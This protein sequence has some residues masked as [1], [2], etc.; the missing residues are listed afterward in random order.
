M[1]KKQ[2]LWFMTLFSLI[3]VLGVYYVTM[4]NDVLEKVNN[5]VEEQQEE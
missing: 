4:P 1:T 5:Q 2:N 3:L